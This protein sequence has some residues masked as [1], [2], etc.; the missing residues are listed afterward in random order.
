MPQLQIQ[1][2]EKR[3]DELRLIEGHLIKMRC[4]VGNLKTAIDREDFTYLMGSIEES[5]RY[6]AVLVE[7]YVGEIPE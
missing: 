4:E 7:H 5:L 1:T 3:R 6:A 2:Q